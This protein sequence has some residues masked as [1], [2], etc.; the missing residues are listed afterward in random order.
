[1]KRAIVTKEPTVTAE[2]TGTFV[3]RKPGWGV[4]GNGHRNGG[5]SR[6]WRWRRREGPR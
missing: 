5:V 6:E 3:A 2:P 4:N 1:M